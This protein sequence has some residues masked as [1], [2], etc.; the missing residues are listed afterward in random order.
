[1][2][3]TS[4][5]PPRPDPAHRGTFRRLEEELRQLGFEP[6]EE[7]SRPGYT[8]YAAADSSALITVID[9]PGRFPR[10]WASS[11][12]GG[13]RLWGMEWCGAT[14]PAVQLIA[15][16]AALNDDPEAALH[17]A[18]AAIGVHELAALTVPAST[19]D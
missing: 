2:T 12:V 3:D 10:V 11:R 6:V 13:N 19:V 16:Y 17:G 1:M 8:R 14:P 9:E 4:T 15:L 18:A 5:G 7:S